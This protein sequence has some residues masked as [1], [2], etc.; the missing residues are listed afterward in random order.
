LLVFDLKTR[1]VALAAALLGVVAAASARAEIPVVE[2]VGVVHAVSAQHVIQALERAEKSG[3]PVVILRIDTPGGVVATTYDLVE[4]ILACRAPVVVFV[5]PAGARATSAGFIIAISAD[6]VAMAPGTNM[7]A[8]HPVSMMGEMDETMAKKAASDV[9]AFVRG[10]A[11]Q[12]GR[13]VELAEKAVLESRSFTEKEALEAHLSDLI[14]NDV[15]ELI[16]ALDGREVK[17]FDGKVVRLDLKGQ[18]TVRVEMS[19]REAILATIA[20]PEILFL[21]LLGALAGL[22][23]EI[24]HPGLIFPGIIGTLCL[25]LFLFATQIIPIN[26]AGV[27]LIVLAV[28]LFAAE[29]KVASYG[30]LTV[31]GLVSMILGAMMLIDAPIPEMR[32]PLMVVVPA[33]LAVAA[34]AAFIV[35]MILSAQRARVTTGSEGMVGEKGAVVTALEPEGWVTVRGE[36]WRARATTPLAV[37]DRVTVEAVEGLTL[38]VRPGG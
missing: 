25:I 5:G 3:A 29:V 35:R 16:A 28:A 32:V 10:K 18:K 7:G 13:N 22:G 9:A 26:G 2:L 17:R 36:R 12:R 37:G 19:V 23:T 4:R 14:V 34:W 27:L 31:G 20:R 6:V 24:S 8:A 38:L 30:L 15:P 1:A 33:A 21:L 11:E